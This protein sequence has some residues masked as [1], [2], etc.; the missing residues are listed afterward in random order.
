MPIGL[1]QV[2]QAEQHPSRPLSNVLQ[3]GQANGS[4]Q[5][6]DRTP[7]DT[8]IVLI[9]RGKLSP[10]KCLSHLILE[11]SPTTGVWN[12]GPHGY[13]AMFGYCERP[14]MQANDVILRTF[15]V[16]FQ[17][18]RV[19]RNS[20]IVPN[21][22]IIL[23]RAVHMKSFPNLQTLAPHARMQNCNYIN[24]QYQQRLFPLFFNKM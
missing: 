23:L 17:A 21:R 13:V 6:S 2:E 22:I 4:D 19:R 18:G 7:N 14:K 20:L 3:D 1:E 15:S 12:F 9:R 5:F 8:H 16:T 11:I 24:R 10:N